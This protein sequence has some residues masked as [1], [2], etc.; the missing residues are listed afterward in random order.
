LR[1]TAYQA[2]EFVGCKF[3]DTRLDKVEFEGSAFVDCSFEGEVRNV[4]FSKRGFQLERFPP[5]EMI[6][7]D[8]RRAQLRWTEFRN[9]DLDRVLFPSDDDHIIVQNWPYVLSRLIG[10]FGRRKDDTSKGYTGFFEHERK[11][12]GSK[13]K[14]GILNRGDLCEVGGEGG[15]QVVL[16]VIRTAEKDPQ[17][18]R[19]TGLARLLGL[20]K[21][22]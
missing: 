16:D 11:W 7:V 18:S 14:V 17:K 21:E 13:Q 8:F 5:N 12:L 19:P 4:I 1:E 15:L 10:F 20:R 22:Q 2:S 6:N 9:L 3:K